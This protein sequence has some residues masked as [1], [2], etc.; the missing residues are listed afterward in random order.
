[1]KGVLLAAGISSRLRPL[2]GTIP[3]CLLEIG[4]ASILERTLGNLLV[5][6]IEDIFIVTGYLEHRLR[7]FISRKF[8]RRNIHFIHNRD[9]ASTNNIY[10]FWLAKENILRESI[11]L[12]DSDIIFDG[13]IIGALLQSGHANCLA[14]KRKT[15]L[16]AEE[17]KVAVD[18]SC[19]ILDISKEVPP[20]IAWG[21]SIGIEKFAPSLLTELFSVMDRK[22]LGE[23]KVHE[24]YEAAFQ[25]VI[26]RG[27]DIFAVDVGD[28]RAI[29]ID[30]VEDIDTAER[31]VIPYLPPLGTTGIDTLS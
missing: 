22:I 18:G 2:T 13:R 20:A 8:P 28:Y 23:K 6:G 16:S 11:L 26:S 27:H 3:K 7:N 4:G 19:R 5:W 1:M 29:E 15:A 14:V 31:E 17:I 25:E 21:E 24:F 30:T 12:L 9:Y 10:S